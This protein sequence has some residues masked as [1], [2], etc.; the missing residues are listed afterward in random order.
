M[1]LL[2]YKDDTAILQ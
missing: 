2:F 1:S